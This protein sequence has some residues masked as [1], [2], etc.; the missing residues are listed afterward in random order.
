MRSLLFCVLSFATATL[1][2]NPDAPTDELRPIPDIQKEIGNIVDLLSTTN[3]VLQGESPFDAV[4]RTSTSLM[5]LDGCTSAR[6]LL[7]LSIACV[8]GVETNAHPQR[9]MTLR[10]VCGHVL[11]KMQPADIVDSVAPF[12]G[13]VEDAKLSACL[14]SFLDMATLRNGRSNPDFGSLADV[15]K[16]Q[17]KGH[18]E[19]LVRY[20]FRV[21]PDKALPEVQKMFSKPEAQAKSLQ[22]AASG[23]WWEQIYAAEKIRQRPNLRDPELIG[24]LKKSKHAVV[25]EIVQEIENV[26]EE[27]PRQRSDGPD[28]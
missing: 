26:I 21:N 13:L 7:Q 9:Q 3:Y 4:V 12:Y 5:K 1:A 18:P 27:G 2:G 17:M 22:S 14:D 19:R 20:M 15:V 25:R 23:E 10:V 16:Q 24:Q 8:N 11:A 6:L 28:F